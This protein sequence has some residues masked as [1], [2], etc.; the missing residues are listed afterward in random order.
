MDLISNERETKFQANVRFF[1]RIL[2]NETARTLLVISRENC[3][4]E[5]D[6][7][8]ISCKKFLNN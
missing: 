1:A 8:D 2:V 6:E 4:V 7:N 3:A 5:Q